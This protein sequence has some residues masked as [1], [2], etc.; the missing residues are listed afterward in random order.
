MS[1]KRKYDEVIIISDDEDEQLKA[2]IKL[3]KELNLPKPTN[4]RFSGDRFYLNK[5][6]S[7]S[8]L[9]DTLTI[10]EIIDVD[11]V[12]HCFFCTFVF[13]IEFFEKIIPKNKDIPI[14]LVKHWS[15]ESG[16]KSGRTLLQSGKTTFCICH[17]KLL[18]RGNMHAKFWL[19]SFKDFIR[20]VITSANLTQA[21]WY[22]MSQCI[23]V[24]DFPLKTSNSTNLSEFETI[25]FDYWKHMTLGL[26]HKWL[27]KYDFS[28]A[29]V[30]LIPSIP[31]FHKGDDM[32]KYGHMRI[33][34]L[35]KKYSITSM[36][37][38][39]YFQCS[40]IG[41]ITEK[42]LEEFCTSLG[43]RKEK[44]RLVYPT[45]Q[46]VHNTKYVYFMI[47]IYIKVGDT[48]SWNAFPTTKELL[49]LKFSKVHYA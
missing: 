9:E 13:E 36:Q 17:P 4:L 47:K 7:S 34:S 39:V 28:A 20:V 38:E 43:C 33:R 30:D 16:E 2:A 8:S 6:D 25:L 31:G 37:S 49:F 19:L 3:S 22:A 41:S 29:K 32:Y 12:Q 14:T 35:L 10:Q 1:K 26:P 15:K 18:P 40:S 48:R 11:N 42:W 27:L 21:D 24:Q 5:L 23:F 46:S 44:F 45:L